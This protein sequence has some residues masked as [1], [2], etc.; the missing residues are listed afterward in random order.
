MAVSVYV[1]SP[2]RRLT[3]NRSQVEGHGKNVAELLEDLERQFPGFRNL[4]F[5]DK[6]QIPPHINIYVNNREISTLEGTATPLRNGD[7]VAVIPALAGGEGDSERASR[8]PW[9][10]TEQQV[11]RYSRHIIMPQVGSVGQRKLMEARVLIL[12]AGGLGSPAALYLALAGIGTLGIVDFDAVDL[13]N[14][15]RQILH[16]TEDVGRPKVESARET[17]SAHNPDVRV[18]PHNVA[19][20]SEN[21][22]DIITRYDIVVNGMDNFPA[23]YLT[24]DACVFLKKPLVDGSVLLFDGQA[25]V[26]LPGKGCYRCLYPT[27]PPP[28]LVPSC[29]DAGVVGALPG[30]IG[31]IQ[32]IETIKLILG[33]GES[34]SGRLLLFDA[35]SMELRTVR[36]H[37]DPDCV[38]CGDHPTVTELIDYEEFCGFPGASH[39][40]A[41]PLAGRAVSAGPQS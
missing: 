17:I 31:C 25:T 30:V 33:A 11:L 20:T 22:L 1:P 36:V 10:L 3:G 2:F 19:L 41:A 12:G 27:P 13:S 6:N 35:L 5:N 38:V 14:L 32:A 7:Q 4:L 34:L 21:A 24:N 8:A 29:A 18:V 37:R 16:R 39:A 26:Y 23:R 40:A 15:Q 9:A 28:G